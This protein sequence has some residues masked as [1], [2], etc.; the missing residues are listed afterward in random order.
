ML[1]YMCGDVRRDG[2]FTQGEYTPDMP[3]ATWVYVLLGG[4]PSVSEWLAK[5]GKAPLKHNSIASILTV[6]EMEDLVK[7]VTAKAGEGTAFLVKQY[8]GDKMH[9]PPGVLHAVHNQQTCLKIA[10]DVV[11]QKNMQLYALSYQ[12]CMGVTTNAHDYIACLSMAM[13]YIQSCML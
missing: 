5:K 12:K 10:Y 3:L 6:K 9:V 11:D 8:A 1:L 2:V 7:H 13:G 4:V